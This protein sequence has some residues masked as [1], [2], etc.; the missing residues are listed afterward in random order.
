MASIASGSAHISNSYITHPQREDEFEKIIEDI[1]EA[2]NKFHIHYII[3][4]N[5]TDHKNCLE[6]ILENTVMFFY[7][8]SMKK[9]NK[10]C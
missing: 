2:L 7:F 3:L 6:S 9:T 1:V 8:I 5:Y 4:F 10:I